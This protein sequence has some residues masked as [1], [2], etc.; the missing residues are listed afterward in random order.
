MTWLI[1]VGVVVAVALAVHFG[2]ERRS[3]AKIRARK[4]RAANAGRVS[5]AR[6]LDETWDLD[7]DTMSA[8]VT[9]TDDRGATEAPLQFRLLRNTDGTFALEPSAAPPWP[10]PKA[11]AELLARP[12]G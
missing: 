10:L 8:V 6:R 3:R 5:Y 7:L 4:A 2:E 12:K 1:V 9:R 11:I